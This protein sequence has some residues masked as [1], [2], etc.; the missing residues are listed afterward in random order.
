ML[1]L[2]EPAVR[3]A[4][5]DEMAW[6]RRLRAVR[7]VVDPHAAAVAVLPGPHADADACGLAGCEGGATGGELQARP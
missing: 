1:A 4:D 7:D 5:R 3:D 6:L 2:S